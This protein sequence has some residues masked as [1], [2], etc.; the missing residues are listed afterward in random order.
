MIV[1]NRN[2]SKIKKT[3][4]KTRLVPYSYSL[5]E[6]KKHKVIKNKNNISKSKSS[7]SS[8]NKNSNAINND[9][10]INNIDHNIS[11][12]QQEGAGIF[13]FFTENRKVR[14]LKK[15]LKKINKHQKK[16]LA[17]KILL[18]NLEKKFNQTNE[19][20]T[21]DNQALFLVMRLEFLIEKKISSNPNVATDFNRQLS[22]ITNKKSELN[23]KLQEYAKNNAK[24]VINYKSK[25][26]PFKKY[27]DKYNKQLDKLIKFKTDNVNIYALEERAK[28]LADSPK[29]STN[30]KKEEKEL[31][32]INKKYGELFKMTS[33]YITKLYEPLNQ[34]YSLINNIEQFIKIIEGIQNAAQSNE[35]Y[36]DQ[37]KQLSQDLFEILRTFKD[38]EISSIGD[39]LGKIDVELKN[40]IMQYRTTD[41]KNIINKVIQDFN[42]LYEIILD[43]KKKHE[44][45][46]SN[47]SNIEKELLRVSNTSEI[48]ENCNVL[49]QANNACIQNLRFVKHYLNIYKTMGGW[50]TRVGKTIGGA[51]KAI[52]QSGGNVE[53]NNNNDPDNF[54]EQFSNAKLESINNSSGNPTNAYLDKSFGNFKTIL[55]KDLF[56]KVKDFRTSDHKKENFID[57]D[58]LKKFLIQGDRKRT[59]V[60]YFEYTRTDGNEIC[61]IYKSS[62]ND[63]E[64]TIPGIFKEKKLLLQTK[65]N[66]DSA[67]NPLV[68]IFYPGLDASNNPP[69]ILFYVIDLTKDNSG[70]NPFKNPYNNNFIDI[71]SNQEIKNRRLLFL[72]P[73]SSLPFLTY[74]TGDNFDIN[75][76]IFKQTIILFCDKA[77]Q[78]YFKDSRDCLTNDNKE[79]YDKAVVQC[80]MS[81]FYPTTN[82]GQYL[83]N[84]ATSIYSLYFNADTRD[85]NTKVFQRLILNKTNEFIS[86]I[87]TF[88]EEEDIKLK[89]IEI[90]ELIES[91]SIEQ[92]DKDVII[93]INFK[94]SVMMENI[95]NFY[96][97]ILKKGKDDDDLIYNRPINALYPFKLRNNQI[98][99]DNEID[100]TGD[101]EYY[102]EIKPIGIDRYSNF[103]SIYN[104][105]TE[106]FSIKIDDL[107]GTA[108]GTVSGTV[109]Q[110]AQR[111]LIRETTQ[112][113][114]ETLNNYLE[115]TYTDVS[116]S[117]SEKEAQILTLIESMINTMKDNQS[118][119][120]LKNQNQIQSDSK[121]NSDSKSDSKSDSES[122][123]DFE[124]FTKKK[125]TKKQHGGA[126]DSIETKLIKI[127]HYIRKLVEVEQNLE[128]I[129]KKD[130]KPDTLILWD[131]EKILKETKVSTID[132]SGF[133][134][135]QNELNTIDLT[136]TFTSN[137]IDI[138]SLTQTESVEDK[139]KSFLEFKLNINTRDNICP[140]ENTNIYDDI[141]RYIET[142]QNNILNRYES[143][144][145]SKITNSEPQIRNSEIARNDPGRLGLLIKKCES[146]FNF[147]EEADNLSKA[148][149]TRQ[150]IN[151][152]RQNQGNRN[153]NQGN[154]G[155]QGN[156]GRDGSRGNDTAAT[157]AATGA[158][159]NNTNV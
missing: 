153:R 119:G 52:I 100:S 74:G 16:I 64:F 75:T 58:K 92:K 88:T 143:W 32:K 112:E 121:S 102:V 29:K 145:A 73:K 118:G 20:L 70:G 130:P 68:Y 108:T 26:A 48:S 139:L 114:E 65:Y 38:K 6:T 45:I 117:V 67:D 40:I 135:L 25:I 120:S 155:N 72:D 13:S 42:Q 11:N 132:R 109:G 10:S 142:N 151:I 63:L 126:G 125:K 89:G 136:S 110:A 50:Q 144:N 18:E 71:D 131:L 47:I 157:G 128:E 61:Y 147:N 137:Y 30:D 34:I 56:G 146:L 85:L 129:K 86:N 99:F 23:S 154:Q 1:K 12:N 98:N 103:P 140:F 66:N 152:Q 2:Y 49:I 105:Y 33:D 156:R 14:K 122:D 41:D 141:K 7:N 158:T 149:M 150:I 46:L 54:F 76:N 8:N 93:N 134:Q 21:V 113:R 94:D 35:N 27:T 124:T 96:L 133:I 101:I 55:D 36:S 159:T 17:N 123:F 31:K 82:E 87:S 9:N 19:K 62:V 79:R 80:L 111:E 51:K 44:S 37:I 60:G 78:L 104:K 77:I 43:T 95:D 24:D 28:L 57:I 91:T 138:N 107:Q 115:K 22:L 3:K 97:T 59:G 81:M 15:I 127:G 83:K 106:I 53:W 69:R 5:K 90:E 4:K 39:N 148:L 84:T 116:N